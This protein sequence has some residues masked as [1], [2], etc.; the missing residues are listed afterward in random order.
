MAALEHSRWGTGRACLA[1]CRREVVYEYHQAMK[2]EM[3]N[4]IPSK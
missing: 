3:V 4:A 1:L 2:T